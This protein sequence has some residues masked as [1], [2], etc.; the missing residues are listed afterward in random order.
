MWCSQEIDDQLQLVLRVVARKEGRSLQHLRENAPDRPNV[1]GRRVVHPRAQYLRCSI[2][3]GAHILGHGTSLK[4]LVKIHSGQAEVADFEI[5]VRIHQQ[6][7]RF[8]IAM[9]NLCRMNVLHPAKNLIEEKLAVVVR[10]CLRTFQDRRQVSFHEL[11]NNVNVLE[12]F[13]QTR[14][15]N[16]PDINEVF[17]PQVSQDAKL[18]QSP[19]CKGDVLEG[20]FDLFY[21][22][23]FIPLLVLSCA[24]DAI[25]PL[26][27][28]L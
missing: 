17:M 7:P 11:R 10:Q 24:N 5:T 16:A 13:L 3:A 21:G 23:V 20:V 25:R 2:P 14:Q 26:A 4:V 8:Q 28:R 19:F 27:D 22:D 9:D 6:V 1:N 15:E 18:S 12:T